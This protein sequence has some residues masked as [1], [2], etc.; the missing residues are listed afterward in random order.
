MKKYIYTAVLTLIVINSIHAQRMLPKQKGLEFNVG[1][2]STENISKN[3]YVNIG[4]TT[5]GKNGNYGLFALEYT[6]RFYPYKNIRIPLETFTA[7][8]GYSVFL[9]GDAGRNIVLNAALT[10]VAGY[11]TINR[12]ETALDD[13]AKLLSKNNF[14]YGAGGRLS[15]ETYLSDHFVLLL[16][17]RV[18]TLWGTDMERFRPGAGVGLR[19]NF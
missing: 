18:K 17:G 13:G 6:Y 2:L 7:E 11:E 3:Y 10:G 12:G 1:T 4:M 14:V 8:G 15:V 5:N 19:I 9:L 16:Q